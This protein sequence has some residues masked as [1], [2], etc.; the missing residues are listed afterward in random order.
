MRRDLVTQHTYMSPSLTHREE[1]VE[2]VTY[3]RVEYADR[4]EGRK[5][6]SGSTWTNIISFN[7]V[8]LYFTPL[9]IA[10]QDLV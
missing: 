1:E 3:E 7:I 2:A 4:G 9:I 6:M 10:G 5:E 8:T